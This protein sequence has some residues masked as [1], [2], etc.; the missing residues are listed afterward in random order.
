[1]CLLRLYLVYEVL[2]HNIA[3]TMSDNGNR[4]SKKAKA[5]LVSLVVGVDT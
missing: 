4:F 3:G 2:G 1:M 5:K